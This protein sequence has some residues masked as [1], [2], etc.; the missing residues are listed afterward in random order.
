MLWQMEWVSSEVNLAWLSYSFPTEQ[1]ERGWFT[2]LLLLGRR[3][4]NIYKNL[5][6]FESKRLIYK[7]G[8]QSTNHISSH[9]NCYWYKQRILVMK[10]WSLTSRRATDLPHERDFYFPSWT[11]CGYPPHSWFLDIK[12]YPCHPLPS[13]NIYWMPITCQTPC[14]MYKIWW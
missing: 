11:R 5:H 10:Y 2:T 13:K 4:H 7:V 12:P 8:L 3:K 14:Q 1:K 9:V 6:E